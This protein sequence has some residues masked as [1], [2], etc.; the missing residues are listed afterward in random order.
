[1]S[2]DPVTAG[3]DLVNTAI[4]RI[5]PDAS[6][7]EK[8]KVALIAAEMQQQTDINKIEA[9]NASIFVCGWRPFIG[10]TCGV[11]FLYVAVIE[12]IARFIS[13]VIFRYVGSFP[14]IDTNLTLQVMLGLLGIA[15]LR[16]YEKFKGVT[17]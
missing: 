2:L 14:A 12:P 7:A 11:S 13:T 8:Q 9:A 10:W 4:S 16:T 15:S 3:I 5:W 17:K 6:E 1:M